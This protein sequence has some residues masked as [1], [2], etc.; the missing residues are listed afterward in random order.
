MNLSREERE[1]IFQEE[2]AKR[3][4]LGE[5]TEEER[6]FI[7]QEELA[8]RNQLDEDFSQLEPEESKTMNTDESPIVTY[9]DTDLVAPL[10][11]GG[12]TGVIGTIWFF[13]MFIIFGI[14]GLIWAFVIAF[15]V[16][17]LLIFGLRNGFTPPEWNIPYFMAMCPNCHFKFMYFMNDAMHDYHPEQDHTYNLTCD[18]CKKP[19]TLDYKY[20]GS[21]DARWDKLR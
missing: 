13:G 3:K 6:E 21:Y 5:L 17:L 4:K 19:F 12:V 2:L 9:K 15:I 10:L 16:F 7:F 20:T 14:T 1:R 8:K 18:K 11:R